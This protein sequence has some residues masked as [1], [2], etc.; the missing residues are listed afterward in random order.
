MLKSTFLKNCLARLAAVLLPSLFTV[1]GFAEEL[2]PPWKI[3]IIRS[4][5]PGSIEVG[6]NQ[7]GALWAI[8]RLQPPFQGACRSGRLVTPY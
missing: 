3:A 7:S 4:N 2:H 8:N 5:S 1:A 6:R